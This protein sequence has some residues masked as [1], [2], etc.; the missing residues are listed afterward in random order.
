MACYVTRLVSYHYLVSELL[1]GWLR[2]PH[3]IRHSHA[4]SFQHGPS[5]ATSDTGPDMIAAPRPSAR[6]AR[7]RDLSRFEQ[8]RAPEPGCIIAWCRTH[9]RHS[10]FLGS[11]MVEHPA[12][13]RRVVGSSPTRGAMNSSKPPGQAACA[14]GKDC[15]GFRHGRLVL[16]SQP[17]LTPSNLSSGCCARDASTYTES[18]TLSALSSPA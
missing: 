17:A 16:R 5:G 8:L 18:W 2:I 9:P 14:L 1:E 7:V 3:P 4:S 12:V 6:C 15:G 13:N 10:S 11:S